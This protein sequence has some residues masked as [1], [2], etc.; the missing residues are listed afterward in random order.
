MEYVYY[1]NKDGS[2]SYQKQHQDLVFK[3]I[4]CI[5]VVFCTGASGNSF[6]WNDN[7]VLHKFNR[8]IYVDGLG[9]VFDRGLFDVNDEMKEV[10]QYLSDD[11]Y[12]SFHVYFSSQFIPYIYKSGMRVGTLQWAG[13]LGSWYLLDETMDHLTGDRDKNSSI[14]HT[15][16]ASKKENID[17]RPLQG[18]DPRKGGECPYLLNRYLCITVNLN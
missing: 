7:L 5:I 15:Q 18:L 13:I 2:Q 3:I 14:L 11:G 6:C 17:R 1:R 12:Y 16:P 4:W 10:V 9:H 8:N